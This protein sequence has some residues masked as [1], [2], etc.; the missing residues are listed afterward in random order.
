MDFFTKN[1][2][3]NNFLL[4]KIQSRLCVQCAANGACAAKKWL[5]MGNTVI[6]SI[7]HGQQP[8]P[9][10][11]SLPYTRIFIVRLLYQEPYQTGESLKNRLNQSLL[12][13]SSQ[14]I[15]AFM[16][17]TCKSVGHIEFL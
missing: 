16:P 7:S 14:K 6:L 3:G 8:F 9:T 2:C 15:P 11:D 13:P 17:A 5:E 4:K 1:L 10:A 12:S